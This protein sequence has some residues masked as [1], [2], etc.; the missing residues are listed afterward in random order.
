MRQEIPGW[1]NDDE[2][3]ADE[4]LLAQYLAVIGPRFAGQQQHRLA[5]S[6]RYLAYRR[7]IS[8]HD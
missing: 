3:R 2:L 4:A 6:L 7:L 1:D 8:P 5:D